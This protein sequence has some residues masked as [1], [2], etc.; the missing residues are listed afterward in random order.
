MESWSDE[1]ICPAS[2]AIRPC[3]TDGRRGGVRERSE[4]ITIDSIRFLPT[5]FHYSSFP[6]TDT[7]HSKAAFCL[8]YALAVI[9][10]KL[11]DLIF[12]VLP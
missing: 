11:M 3:P 10:Q 9:V 2:W 8:F 4:T 12:H 6:I 7:E 1:G 5:A